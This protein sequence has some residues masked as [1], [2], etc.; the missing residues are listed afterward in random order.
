MIV[1][2]FGYCTRAACGN[3]SW[4]KYAVTYK[5]SKNGEKRNRLPV[6]KP[7]G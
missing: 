1:S 6:E 4:P 5:K 3:P 7:G 2:I